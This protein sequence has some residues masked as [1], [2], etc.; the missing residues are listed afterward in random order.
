MVSLINK[1]EREDLNEWI[2]S[3]NTKIGKLSKELKLLN[4]KVIILEKLLTLMLIKE[5]MEDENGQNNFE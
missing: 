5:T 3:Q 1:Q 4:Q 2:M